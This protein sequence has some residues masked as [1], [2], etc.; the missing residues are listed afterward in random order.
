MTDSRA[1]RPAIVD[2]RRPVGWEAA[3]T[4][5][6]RRADPAG[7]GGVGTP[8]AAAAVR[9]ILTLRDARSSLAPCGNAHLGKVGAAGL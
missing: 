8:I 2:A 5:R 4:R 7:A 6:N 3:R 1:G 9:E